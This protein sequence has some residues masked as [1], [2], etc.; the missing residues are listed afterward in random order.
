MT[1]PVSKFPLY[2]R[3]KISIDFKDVIKKHELKHK[4]EF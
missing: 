4:I 2:L 1:I 3:T